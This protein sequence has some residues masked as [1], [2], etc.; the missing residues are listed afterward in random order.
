[1]VLQA[2]QPVVVAFCA[3]WAQ[4]CQD[5]NSQLDAL[6]GELAG[7]ITMAVL[8]IN[9]SPRTPPM[10]DVQAVPTFILFSGGKP[11]RSRVGITPKYQLH[12]W[13]IE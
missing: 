7:K 1:M 5:I 11:I 6:A 13:S 12:Q 9:E 10:Y 4:Q 3:R 8:D 2:P